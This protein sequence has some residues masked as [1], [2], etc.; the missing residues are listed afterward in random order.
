MSVL[1]TVAKR[2]LEKPQL[3]TSSAFEEIASLLDMKKGRKE[4]QAY[5]EPMSS[6]EKV[7]VK[8]NDPFYS[9]YRFGDD[10]E[11]TSSPAEYGVI[12]IEGPLTYKPEVNMC[13]PDTCNYQEIVKQVEMYA[14]QGKKRILMIHESPGGEAYSMFS[15]ANQARK[16]ADENDIELIGY[17]DGLSASASY[18][19]LSICDKIYSSADSGIGSIGV[20]ISLLNNNGALEKAGLKRQ[21]ITAGASKVPFDKDGEFKEEFLADLQGDVDELYKKFVSH[22]E[23]YRTDMT[24]KD[25]K[26]TEAKVFRAEKALELGLID[27][28]MEVAEFKEKYL[29]NNVGDDS[30]SA[31]ANSNKNESKLMS[32]EKT[33]DMAEVE[34]LKQELATM[35][36]AET[37]RLL[38]AKKDDITKQLSTATF[39]DNTEA[40][41]EF[42]VGAEDAQASMLTNVITQA[43][44]ALASQKES[45]AAELTAAKEEL[46]TSIDTLK[47]EKASLESS[48]EA[49]KEEF[50]QPEAIREEEK[51]T[52]FSIEEK[53]MAQVAKDKQKM[54]GKV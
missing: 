9:G 21:F 13:A 12:K 10:G 15:S 43:T 23:S 1:K 3:I 16:I 11:E 5:F 35:K 36:A 51:E 24:A 54:E 47:E 44:T 17:V 27:E 29:T 7:K 46:Q 25:I 26:A 50:A 53:R 32:K 31:N 33:I 37:S 18:G 42:L 22:V 38:Q 41:V 39:L 28:I 8:M 34:Q 30:P 45:A 4:L 49:V 2:Y 52:N 6:E 14:A 19:W 20:V 48:K 40:V